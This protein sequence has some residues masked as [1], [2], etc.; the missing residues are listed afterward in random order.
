VTVSEVRRASNKINNNNTPG[1]RYHAGIEL[2][3][4]AGDEGKQIP[5]AQPQRI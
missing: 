3:K 4:A 2:I 5:T 1:Q